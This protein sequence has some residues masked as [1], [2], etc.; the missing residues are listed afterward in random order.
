MPYAWPVKYQLSTDAPIVGIAAFAQSLY[1]GTTRGGYL[2]TGVDPSAMAM[3]KL[4]ISQTCSSKRSIV[5]MLGGVVWASPDGLFFGGATGVRNLTENILTREEW[6]AYNPSSISAY[7]IDG[8][9][10]AFYDNG[11]KAGLI[12]SFDS[13]TSFVTTDQYAYAGFQEKLN[14]AL[15]FVNASNHVLKWHAGASNMTMAWRSKEFRFPSPVN[16]GSA[17]VFASAYP[18][19]FRL[20]CDG[21]LK[22]TQTVADAQPFRLP[23]GFVSGTISVEVTGAVTVHRVAVASSMSELGAPDE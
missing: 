5:P 1:V 17:R 11:T 21:V 14:D 3:E 18:C 2:V 22:H 8:R 9:Y 20:Y 19:T 10:F 13:T 4:N 7:E 23:G 6:Q 16:M 12:F 15:Y